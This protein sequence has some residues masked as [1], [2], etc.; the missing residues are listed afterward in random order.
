VAILVH[1]GSRSE[2]P[3]W[4]VRSR[5]ESG[6]PGSYALEVRVAILLAHGESGHLVLRSE[7]GG[8][9]GSY[10]LEASGHPGSYALEAL[11][12]I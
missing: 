12:N 4:F 9:P 8:H 5:S 10:A 11:P 2:W 6:H 7:A 1:L 3:S